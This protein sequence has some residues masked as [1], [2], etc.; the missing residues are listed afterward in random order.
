MHEY[1]KRLFAFDPVLGSEAGDTR[2]DGLLGDVSVD[3]VAH[4]REGVSRALREADAAAPG[5]H[6]SVD[7]AARLEWLE[8]A[9]LR[10]E[11]ATALLVLEQQR[12]HE[13]APYWYVER[14]GTA[15]GVLLGADRD[16]IAGGEALAQRLRAVP[17][18]LATAARTLTDETPQLWLERGLSGLRG[19]TRFVTGVIPAHARTLP[20]T[21][22]ADLAEAVPAA[23]AALDGFAASL[24]GLGASASGRWAAG[25]DYLDAMLRDHHHVSLDAAALADFG[26]ELVDTERR[27]LEQ[28][29]GDI[30][31]TS[32]WREQIDG[33]KEWHPRPEDF[34]RT[35]TGAMLRV[36]EHALA[37]DLVAL[38]DGEECRT[39]WVP[40]YRREGL[41]LGEMSPS[42]PYA[43]GLRSHFLITPADPEGTEEVR[44]QHMR[45]NCYLFATSI[46]GHETY[47]GHHVQYVHHKMGTPVGSVR[48][49]VR[50][51]Q[52]V[53]GWGLYVEDLLV[54]TGF[55]ADE[56]LVLLKQRNA[57]WRALRIV[58]DT[59]LH[60][61]TLS[62]AQA[63]ALL[64]REAGMDEHMA[65]GEVRRYTR[66]DNPTYPSS[67]VLGRDLIHRL[68]DARRAADGD[69]YRHRDFHDWLLSFGSP[70][71][72]L[73][74][75]PTSPAR[76]E[77]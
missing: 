30:D 62:P 10:T 46:A 61:G 52:F 26:A 24:Q 29:A 49:Y 60:A 57:L 56:R 15:F 43:P 68:R 40:D 69:A 12:P 47:P 58:I 66:H 28:L 13:R 42:P 45:D 63:T 74:E 76:R 41:P 48:R 65:A 59:G 3:A 33:L 70:P 1:V 17:D 27:R 37:H 32:S 71:V 23:A 14:L 31:P 50:S 75:R 73:L 2:E 8:H 5:G 21:L 4:Y 53:E 25:T 7:S 39:D 67:Y 55:L 11:L 6:D 19:L 35:Y 72:A 51:P 22:A 38:P 64:Q 18:H 77:G 9:V 34:L 44:R 16:P 36:R 20:P 54:E